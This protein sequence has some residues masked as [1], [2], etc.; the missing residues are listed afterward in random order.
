MESL[1]GILLFLTSSYIQVYAYYDTNWD[2]IGGPQK[3]TNQIYKDRIRKSVKEK[4]IFKLPFEEWL[5]IQ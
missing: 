3:I 1:K 2:V 5:E 4:I